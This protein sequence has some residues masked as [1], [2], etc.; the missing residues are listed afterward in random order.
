M[1]RWLDWAFRCE[2][3]WSVESLGCLLVDR[4]YERAFELAVRSETEARTG[5]RKTR[6]S[7]EEPPT[8]ALPFPEPNQEETHEP[9]A[10]TETEH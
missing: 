10:E 6:A 7:R 5:M 9:E 8:Q 3:T 1:E 2:R 4:A